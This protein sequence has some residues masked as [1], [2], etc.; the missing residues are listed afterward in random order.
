MKIK[1][2]LDKKEIETEY[3][4]IKGNLISWE[5]TI[6]QISNIAMISTT[7]LNKAP[8]P[9][10]VLAIILVGV[11]CSES[12][13]AFSVILWLIAGIWLFLWYN[14]RKKQESLKKLN[15]VLNSGM[16]FTLIFNDKL[17]LSHVVD[18]LTSLLESSERNM[19]IT[20]DIKDNKF[21]DNSSVVEKARLK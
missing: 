16:T 4:K 12:I 17:F 20:F 15:F 13:I 11:I 18:I 8:F 10:W 6:I 7:D 19:N 9:I 5:N 14:T 21:Y 3:L 1:E 2:L